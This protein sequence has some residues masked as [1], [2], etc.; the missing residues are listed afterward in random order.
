MYN[1]NNREWARQPRYCNDN[2]RK[3]AVLSVSI[4]LILMRALGVLRFSY[5]KKVVLIVQGCCHN[6]E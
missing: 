5:S 4:N 6:D 3:W 1:D 2:E